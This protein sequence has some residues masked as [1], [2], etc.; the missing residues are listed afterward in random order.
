MKR[1]LVKGI[2]ELVTCAG[3]KKRGAAMGDAGVIRDGAFLV[4]DGIVRAV[5][6]REE[7]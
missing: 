4:E 2:S 6:K 3:G 7:L 1:Y 5:G